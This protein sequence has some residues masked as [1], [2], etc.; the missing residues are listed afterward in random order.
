MPTDTDVPGADKFVPDAVFG[1]DD[2]QIHHALSRV[3]ENRVCW[4]HA[5][6]NLLVGFQDFRGEAN[7]FAANTARDNGQD[8]DLAPTTRDDVAAC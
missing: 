7:L 8:F 2:E 5:E 6:G 4:N 3:A 1:L